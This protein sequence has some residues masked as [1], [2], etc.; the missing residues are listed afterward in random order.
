MI[1][2]RNISLLCVLGTLSFSNVNYSFSQVNTF[3]IIGTWEGIDGTNTKANFIFNNDS[4]VLLI[5]AGDTAKPKNATMTYRINYS[6]EPVSLDIIMGIR[7]EKEGYLRFIMKIL[8]N[9]KIMIAGGD[10]PNRR[11]S[12]FNKKSNVCELNRRK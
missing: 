11:P 10:L 4:T 5:I 3:N 1:P 12:D 8:S 6:V 7:T 9:D 2:L